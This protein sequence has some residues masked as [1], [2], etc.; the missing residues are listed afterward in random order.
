VNKG[1]AMKSYGLRDVDLEG[2]HVVLKENP[3]K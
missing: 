3:I 2:L 1:E